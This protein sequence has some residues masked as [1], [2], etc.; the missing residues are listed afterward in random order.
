MTPLEQ[1]YNV[2]KNILYVIAG[3]L[4][5]CFEHVRIKRGIRLSQKILDGKTHGK[6]DLK[7]GRWMNGQMNGC[8]D[9]EGLPTDRQ[10]RVVE[11]E[12]CEEILVERRKLQSGKIIE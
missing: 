7:R 4:L 6:E 8:M 9:L 5:Q 12:T 2:K 3:Q 1:H 11:R 10:Q